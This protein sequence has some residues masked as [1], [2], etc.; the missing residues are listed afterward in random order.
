MFC[1]F[2]GDDLLKWKLIITGYVTCILILLVSLSTIG[3]FPVYACI[4]RGASKMLMLIQFVS[5]LKFY[6]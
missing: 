4:V 5:L 1:L 6:P 3:R 2:Y